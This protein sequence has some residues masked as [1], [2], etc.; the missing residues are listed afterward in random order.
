LSARNPTRL[1]SKSRFNDV[2][3]SG[4]KGRKVKA[5]AD[6]AIDLASGSMLFART[7]SGSSVCEVGIEG[8]D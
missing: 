7:A 5:G 2:D 4:T 3:A 1:K 6:V 8:V